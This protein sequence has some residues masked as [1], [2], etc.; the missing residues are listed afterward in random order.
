MAGKG[1]G[2][3]VTANPRGK[4]DEGFVAGTPKPGTVMMIEAAVEPVGGKYSYAVYNRDADGNRPS[5]A[6]CVLLPKQDE[7]RT[8]DTAYADNERCF[9]Y[10]PLPGDELNMLVT[11]SGTGTGDS[12]AIGDL[13]IA[14]DATG[15]LV[16]TTGSPETEM[17]ASKETVSDVVAAGTLVHVEFTGY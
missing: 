11:A 10:Y 13:Y 6:V 4:F 3:I 16:A 1:Q 8:R 7:T 5:G 9:V 17:F 15:L 14:E 2:I 12:Q